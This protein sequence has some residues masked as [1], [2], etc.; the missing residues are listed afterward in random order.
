MP[1]LRCRHRRNGRGAVISPINLRAKPGGF[2]VF[3]D[4]CFYVF[5]D[6]LLDILP[7][8]DMITKSCSGRKL[9]MGEFPSGQR[10]QTVNLLLIASVVR[11]HLPPPIKNPSAVLVGFLLVGE[12]SWIRTHSNPTCRWHVGKTG[13]NTGFLLT[14]FPRKAGH[15]IPVS[16]HHLP[17][18]RNCPAEQ[19]EFS[20]AD[21]PPGHRS[22]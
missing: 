15:R 9:H 20:D 22:G 19:A 6:F 7:K 21:T 14:A 1:P 13:A 5:L 12:D 17:H 11:I 16:F 18:I 4:F 3:L 2:F 8:Y 10:G